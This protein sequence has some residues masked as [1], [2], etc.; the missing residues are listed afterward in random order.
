MSRKGT[1]FATRQQREKGEPV[2]KVDKGE[3]VKK[4]D[5]G[6]PVKKVEEGEPVKKV[7]ERR[8]RQAGRSKGYIRGIIRVI[9]S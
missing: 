9:C 7:E 2:K 1:S 8:A 3:P 6:E 4:V 5:K